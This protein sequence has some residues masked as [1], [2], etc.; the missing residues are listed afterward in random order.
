MKLFLLALIFI[1]NFSFLEKNWGTGNSHIDHEQ[2]CDSIF[3]EEGLWDFIVDV[4]TYTEN[5]KCKMFYNSTGK[6]YKSFCDDRD[7]VSLS[8]LCGDPVLGDTDSIR[9][10]MHCNNHE[11]TN[12]CMEFSPKYTDM[13]NQYAQ[14]NQLSLGS[15]DEMGGEHTT[16]QED[17]DPRHSGSGCEDNT[18]KSTGVVGPPRPLSEICYDKEN[19][20][21]VNQP[22]SK[23]P[24]SCEKQGLLTHEEAEVEA[25]KSL[26]GEREGQSSEESCK[27]AKESV[28]SCS[29]DDSTCRKFSNFTYLVGEDASK[30]EELKGAAHK[31]SVS[32][33][34]KAGHAGA[35]TAWAQYLS[36]LIQICVKKC[37]YET[38]QQEC[39]SDNLPGCQGYKENE[40][41]CNSKEGQVQSLY[42]EAAGHGAMAAVE[43]ANSYLAKGKGVPP[44]GSFKTNSPCEGLSSVPVEQGGFDESK[45][46]EECKN[47]P[48][49]HHKPICQYYANGGKAISPNIVGEGGRPGFSFPQGD[50]YGEGGED[51]GYYGDEDNPQDK[52]KPVQADHNKAP[53]ASGSQGRSG[54]S[55]PFGGGG[56]SGGARGGNSSGGQ[57]V[58]SNPPLDT[59]ILGPPGRTRGGGGFMSSRPRGGSSSNTNKARKPVSLQDFMKAMNRKK[60]YKNKGNLNIQRRV[61]G[62]RPNKDVAAKSENLFKLI[63]MNMARNCAQG[64]LYRCR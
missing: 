64:R 27:V 20:Q 4:A 9:A 21:E 52:L 49:Y 63:H 37:G 45:C 18:G 36:N 50:S 12:R 61:A 8:Y 46:R 23:K 60:K 31:Y 24:T 1:F 30:I 22:V 41:Y 53:G 43:K 7:N 5:D 29:A 54:G 11:S 39:V 6:S 56:G 26:A 58:A 55:V 42:V 51:G 14:G 3:P 35:K 28:D 44:E 15:L 34:N 59:N 13:V 40:S 38:R 16:P 33:I 47:N 62:F 2:I 19:L 48:S 25:I 57:H 32:M 10:Y 17:C